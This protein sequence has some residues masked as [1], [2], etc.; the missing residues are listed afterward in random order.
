MGGHGTGREKISKEKT[1]RLN[2]VDVLL[3]FQQVLPCIYAESDTW[4]WAKK[5][6]V[7]ILL[8]NLY[9]RRGV[10]KVSL[11]AFFKGSLVKRLKLWG[12]LFQ[13]KC[14]SFTDPE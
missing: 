11:R 7:M 6:T 4:I 2:L 8:N 9:W 13:D 14:E 12:W 5:Y 10:V 1:S 3:I